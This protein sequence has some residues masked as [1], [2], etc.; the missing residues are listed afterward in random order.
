GWAAPC[1][2]RD[3]WSVDPAVE[4]QEPDGVGAVGGD[5][6]DRFRHE[7]RGTGAEVPLAL[8]AHVSLRLRVAGLSHLVVGVSAARRALGR[9]LDAAVVDLRRA[10]V[11]RSAVGVDELV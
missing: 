5:L 7:A 11:A 1:A 8:R 3:G 4:A 9:V 10:D 6:V 2:R